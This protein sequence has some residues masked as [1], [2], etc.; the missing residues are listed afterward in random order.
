MQGICSEYI[1]Q[2]GGGLEQKLQQRHISFL[3]LAGEMGF[4]FFSLHPHGIDIE[5]IALRFVAPEAEPK[6]AAT[7]SL[8][9]P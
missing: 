1:E 5:R 6:T 8:L 4:R 3:S 2:A 7:S 9:Y